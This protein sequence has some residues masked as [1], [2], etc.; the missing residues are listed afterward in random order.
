MQRGTGQ[1]LRRSAR[2]STPSAARRSGTPRR[3]SGMR[4]GGRRAHQCR[5]GR[6]QR[7]ATDTQGY[8]FPLRLIR[9][10]RHAAQRRL[11]VREPPRGAG[12]RRYPRA[13]AQ[14][15][16][17]CARSA[18]Y[19]PQLP[20]LLQDHA[21]RPPRWWRRGAWR[22]G[23]AAADGVSFCARAQAQPF[24]AVAT[25]RPMCASSRSPRSTSSSRPETAPPPVPAPGCAV[26]RASC[27]WGI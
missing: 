1:L 25:S 27:G 11:A 16:P 3:H 4:G 2:A 10:F 6:H 14:F 19:Q 24:T 20:I 7:R 8:R 5:A 22:R 17:R 26:T 21:D 13:R 23:V 12:A 18:E 9:T 15:L